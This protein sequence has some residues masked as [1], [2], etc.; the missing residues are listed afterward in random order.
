MGWVQKNRNKGGLVFVDVRDRSG[1]IQVV[2]EEGK[3]VYTSPSVM[4]I[5]Q[6]CT[7]EKA[8]LWDENM[9]FVNPSKVYVDLSDKLYNMKQTVFNELSAAK[10]HV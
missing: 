5:Q 8:T 6:I 10:Y 2:F 9:R 7:Q 3:C 1:I 4:E